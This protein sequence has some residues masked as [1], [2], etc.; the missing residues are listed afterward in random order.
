MGSVND[1]LQ[2]TALPSGVWVE[3]HFP[4]YRLEHAPSALKEK[5]LAS[6]I[7][8]LVHPGMRIA[9]TAGSRGLSDYAPI[10]IGLVQLLLECGA[11][12]FIIPAMGSHGEATAEGQRKLLEGYGITEETMGIP[13][14]SSMEVVQ[15]GVT[16]T[17]EPVWIDRNAWEADGIV[18]FNRIK[19]HTGFRGEYESGLIKMAAIGLGK[20]K[21]AETVHSGGPAKMSERVRMFGIRAIQLSKVLFGVATIENAY[22][23][24]CDIGVWNVPEILEQEPLFLKRAKSM[25]PRIFFEHLDVLVVDRIGKNISGP[26]MDPNITHTYLPGALIDP[27]LRAKRAERV[28]VLDLTEESHGAAMGIG[29]ADVT[30]Q[31]FFRKMDR[32]AT[33]PNCLTGGVTV[34]AKIPMFF[35]NDRLAIQAAVKTLTGPEKHGI[36]MVRIQDTLHLGKIWISE[37]LREEAETHPDV[38]ILSN[39]EP[40]AFQADG[41][42]FV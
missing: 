5:F 20:Q 12:P 40:V 33:Y 4:G 25:M 36:R 32:D 23:Q 34:S 14:L 21:G 15:A 10:L 9:V 27:E 38:T 30:T 28:V 41:N 3:Q 29:M 8:S 39:V 31:R 42:L 7:R 24:V 17:N 35:D 26:G 6:D 37:A 22:D 18:L 2:E 19:P 13:I 1:L 16:E 11:K